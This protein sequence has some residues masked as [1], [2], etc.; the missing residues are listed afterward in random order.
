[1]SYFSSKSTWLSLVDIAQS[2]NSSI[3]QTE[4]GTSDLLE[5]MDLSLNRPLNLPLNFKG[6]EIQSSM[7]DGNCLSFEDYR[8]CFPAYEDNA[9]TEE[10]ESLSQE[11]LDAI[12][13]TRDL[14][15]R[16]FFHFKEWEF[17]PALLQDHIRLAQAESNPEEALVHY[18][19]ARH[20]A[21][22]LVKRNNQ[23]TYILAFLEADRI[24]A[25]IHNLIGNHE[26]CALY[27][28]EGL[29]TIKKNKF[30]AALDMRITKL[31]VGFFNLLGRP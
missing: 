15:H 16:L 18:C 5:S 4:I 14:R 17:G 20:V 9:L 7:L 21:Q 28:K 2:P 10:P 31:T 3:S 1:M 22:T 30:S 24:I 6:S 19:H 23:P 27:A 26:S 11:D 13:I 29:N 25:E 8:P 12:K